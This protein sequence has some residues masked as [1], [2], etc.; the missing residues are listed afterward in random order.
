MLP[1]RPVIGWESLT[2]T[3]RAVTEL[4]AQGLTNR[5]AAE[6]RYIS[7]HTVAHHLREAVRKLNRGSRVELTRIAVQRTQP[8]GEAAG[9]RGF[10]MWASH[11]RGKTRSRGKEFLS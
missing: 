4:V 2:G 6:R 10:T 9:L 8:H 3:E 7:R 1:D 5:E 11:Q